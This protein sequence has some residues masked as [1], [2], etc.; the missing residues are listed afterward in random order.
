MI[1]NKHI[2]IIFSILILLTF[3]IYFLEKNANY[4]FS[5]L[6]T[7]IVF[8]FVFCFSQRKI[9]SFNFLII[10]TYLFFYPVVAHMTV[11]YEAYAGKEEWLYFNPSSIYACMVFIIPYAFSY[12]LFEAKNKNKERVLDSVN[13]SI[14]VVLLL[15][16]LWF[17]ALVLKYKLGLYY[18]ISINKNYQMNLSAYQ[19][20]ID[21]LH[22]FGLAA[23]PLV[24]VKYYKTKKKNDLI[25]F[26]ILL[27]TSILLYVPSGS[28]TMA[29]AHLPPIFIIIISFYEK[30]IF[31]I[32]IFSAVIIFVL[33]A[34]LGTN[35]V[36]EKERNVKVKDSLGVLVHRLGDFRNTGKV[37][38][39]IPNQYAFR[40]NE[41]IDKLWQIF[42][43][44]ILR[45]NIRNIV[46]FNEGTKLTQDLKISPGPWTSEPITLI[47]DLYSRF[48]WKGIFIG[49]LIIGL[50]TSIFDSLIFKLPKEM[51]VLVFYVHSRYFFQFYT[52]SLLVVFVSFFRESFISFAFGVVFLGVAIKV[53]KNFKNKRGLDH[54]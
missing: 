51:A 35:R 32:G 9:L 31:K 11:F 4:F 7:Y 52:S 41:G 23:I 47:G 21:K 16:L 46:D 53:Q 14:F 25:M 45:Q 17:V 26:V 20:I 6:G 27:L 1:S 40:G 38:H 15:F 2:E 49:G 13:L 10:S 22:V 43:P 30:Q 29:I 37:I 48:S 50:L 18:H 39:K 12:K 34:A 28:R 19:N 36:A 5:I 42:I 33:I 24:F 44:Y 8:Y 54:V 3:P